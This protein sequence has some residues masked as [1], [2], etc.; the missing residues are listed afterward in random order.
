MMLSH[1]A[2]VRPKPRPNVDVKSACVF[3]ALISRYTNGNRQYTA[4]SAH[5]MVSSV[6]LRGFATFAKPDFAALLRSAFSS[7][8]TLLRRSFSVFFAAFSWALSS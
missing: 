2:N 7:R 4:N 8:A 3:V 1:K 5:T 6:L